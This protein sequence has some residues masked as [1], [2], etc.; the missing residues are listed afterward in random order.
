MRRKRISLLALE[1]VMEKAVKAT[2]LRRAAMDL[3]ARREHSVGELQEKL[4]HTENK[5]MRI[6]LEHKLLEIERQMVQLADE[7]KLL[8]HRPWGVEWRNKGTPPN[9]R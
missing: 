3:L 2:D 5:Q 4:A 8:K 1:P 9:R 7:K 6:D